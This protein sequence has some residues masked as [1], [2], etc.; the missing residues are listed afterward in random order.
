MSATIY[1]LSPVNINTTVLPVENITLP[2][3]VL[4]TLH[5]HSGNEFPT[6]AASPG[7]NPKLTFRTPFV[8]AYNLFGLSA[9]KVTALDV[10]L[11]K[12]IN[13]VRGGAASHPKLSLA[14]SA[15]GYAHIT[16][17]SV[18]QDGILMADCE[19]YYLSA[20]GQT[21]P[22]ASVAANQSLPS[23]ASQPVLH[24][25]GPISVNGTVYGGHSQS[26]VQMGQQ[27]VVNR[28]DGDLYPR[29]CARTG[30]QP[31][32]TGDHMDPIALNGALG[33]QGANI[34]SNVI[35]YY[36]AYDPTTGLN[37]SSNSVSVTIGS[38]RIHPATMDVAQGS[39]AKLPYE[40]LCLSSSS[41]NPLAI[42]TSATAPSVP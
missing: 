35:V 36:R 29:V 15:I 26:S 11:A 10:Y 37:S 5:Q 32:L 9:L 23:L 14:S 33:Y 40:V 34:S 18:N 17:W 25:L 3:D 27:A 41:T 8:G 19:I 13:L 42:S 7:A 38:G 12:F 39:V 20:D 6:L 16:G 30:A 28:T 31:R 21:H 22:I 4:S 1:S 24:T 2:H